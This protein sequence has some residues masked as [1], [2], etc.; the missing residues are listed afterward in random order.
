MADQNQSHF[1][2]IETILWESHLFFLLDLHLAR[3]KKSADHFSFPCN[4]SSIKEK[5]KDIGKNFITNEKYKVRILVNSTGD[6]TVESEI[7]IPLT[8][9]PAKTVFSEI[10]IDKHDD[11]FKHKTTNRSLYN[12]EYTAAKKN[13]FYDVLFLNQDNEVTEGAISNISIQ[14]NSKYFTPP[15]KC[16][17]LPGVYR[18]YLL[19]IEHFPVI[20]QV[21]HK[22]DIFTADK[23]F[24]INSVRKIVPIILQ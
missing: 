20:E 15:L 2:L 22:E 10:Q 7:L 4:I 17:L 18:T 3:L 1:S 23:T 16:G 8:E 6:I 5:L 11:F 24:L 12:S 9:Y 13:G 19:N 14:L 21:L